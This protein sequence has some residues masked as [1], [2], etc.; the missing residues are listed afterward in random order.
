MS[1]Q[2]LQFVWCA[3]CVTMLLL[4]VITPGALVTVWFAA[5]A[6]I[7]LLVS[8]F[9]GNLWVQVAVFTVASVAL[10]LLT[11]P[12]ALRLVK[13]DFTPTNADRIIGMVGVVTEPITLDETGRVRVDGLDWA[14]KAKMPIAAGTRVS[15]DAISGAT[16]TVHS[17]CETVSQ[18]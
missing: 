6:F 5:G 13:K 14:A 2:T 4:E 7:T 18:S 10:L 12:L 3:V 8:L 9:C 1:F 15:V 11:R 17:I 16:V